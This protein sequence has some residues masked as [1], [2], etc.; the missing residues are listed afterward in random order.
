MSGILISVTVHGAF[1][2]VINVGR[3]RMKIVVVIKNSIKWLVPL[4]LGLGVA[5]GFAHLWN[6]REKNVVRSAKVD[7]KIP[8]EKI[9]KVVLDNGMSI[10]LF[11]DKSTPRV[12]VQIAYDIGSAI[13]DSGE[14]GLAH[15]IEHMI[16]KGTDKLSESDID[17]V[18]RKF[19]A[20][21]N[22]FTCNDATSYYFEADKANW[23]PFVDILADCMQNSRFDEQH[24]A[25]ELKTVI[26]ELNMY[27]DK[28]T[29]MMFEKAFELVFPASHPYHFPIIGYKEELASLSAARLKD[30]YKKYYHPNRAAL[31]IV[32]DIDLDEAEA[33]A[34]KNFEPVPKY[35]GPEIERKFHEMVPS[36]TS[37]SL[38]MYEGIQKEWLGLFWL[39]P[40]TRSG[41][42]AIAEAAEEII[43][44]SEGSRLHR[45][46]VDEDMIAD[47][48]MS[49]AEQLSENGVFA[50]FVCPKEGMRERCLEVVN[51]EILKVINSGVTEEEVANVVTGRVTS[52]FHEIESPRDLVHEWFTSYFETGDEEAVFRRPSE[53]NALESSMVQDYAKK[54]LDPFNAHK[55]ELLPLPESK[56]PIW[57]DAKAREVKIEEAILAAHKRTTPVE[58]PS[59]VKTL[60]D[61]ESFEFNFPEPTKT[62]EMANGLEVVLYQDES[63]PLVTANC[64][65][66]DAEFFEKSKDGLAIKC[67]MDSLIEGSV[68]RTKTE[69]VDFFNSLGADYA[70]SS[71]GAGVSALN[72]NFF[73]ALERFFAVLRQPV[74]AKNSLEK[75]KEL[76]VSS[77]ERSHD[78]PRA[79]AMRVFSNQVYRDTKFA[80]TF[81]DA[82]E[83]TKALEVSSAQALHRQNVQP[84]KMI[85]CIAGS[86]NIEEMEAK[87]NNLLSNWKGDAYLETSLG[88]PNFKPGG[89]IDVNMLR[90]Q[91][92]LIMGQPSEV[93]VYD[94]DRIPLSILNSIVFESLGSRIYKVREQTGLFYNA[95]GGF[96]AQSGKKPGFDYMIAILSPE[97]IDDSENIFKSMITE[98]SEKGITAE[99]LEQSKQMYLKALV[100]ISSTRASLASTMG[101][102]TV[103]NLGFDY[104]KKAWNRVQ[105]LTVEEINRVA[106]KYA[107]TDQMAR[108]RVGRIK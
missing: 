2:V 48:V 46:L 38:K 88:K 93:T 58:E 53:Y 89:K 56:K 49:R 25:S 63:L 3:L 9:R 68:G 8:K 81:D 42:H 87:L 23:K 101:S 54:Y 44:G 66:R 32:G 107:V 28:H 7:F 6:K 73:P 43:G 83:V 10:L 20:S 108:V 50:V 97:T 86:F 85:L 59:F 5:V 102:L 67:M 13:E 31:F 69:N 33:Y 100:E 27:K 19:G 18:A 52:F 36:L 75:V 35:E 45:R 62:F 60:G 64:R 95:G 16:F 104:Y 76:F 29:R 34:R 40:G 92:I 61:P 78:S 103:K 79:V 99:E 4:A 90:D 21:L 14:R 82:I 98:L 39:I 15:L 77:Y 80:W 55:I 11:Q 37:Q 105:N 12:L 74:F 70:F 1:C 65:F 17:A 22:A 72:S 84:T 24:L 41:K 96:A 30:F 106:K 91:A 26:Q 71:S 94:E 57:E 51:E 47:G